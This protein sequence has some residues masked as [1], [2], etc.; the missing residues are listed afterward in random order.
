MCHPAEKS[1]DEFEMTLNL[2]QPTTEQFL[3]STYN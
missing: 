1:G 2:S 3:L